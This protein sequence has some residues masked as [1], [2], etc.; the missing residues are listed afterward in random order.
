[1]GLIIAVVVICAFMTLLAIPIFATCRKCYRKILVIAEKLDQHI[2][3][4]ERV[5]KNFEKRRV[6]EHGQSRNM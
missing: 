4:C 2:F 6:K 3:D 5:L 1:M